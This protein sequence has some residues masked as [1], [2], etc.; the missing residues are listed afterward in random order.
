MSAPPGSIRWLFW[1]ELKL[2]WYSAGAGKPG[3][4][5]KPQRRPGIAGLATAALVWLA[6]H[7]VA[8]YVI[9]R[10]G[11]I[12]VADPRVLVAVTA[13]LFGCMT[14]MLSTALKSS[15]MVLFERGDLDLLLSSPLPSRSIFT[16]R[17][18]SVAAGTA[19]MY[20][21][22]LAPFAHAGALLGHARWLAVYPVILGSATVIACAAMLMTLGLVRVLGA[23][24]TRVV[25]QVIG[26][27]AGASLFLL[28]QLFHYFSS[29]M[30]AR[31]TAAFA[32]AF[33]ANGALGAA[34]PVWLP[35]RALLG[36]PLP[37]LGIALVALAAFA[38]TAG[39]THRFFVHGLQQAASTGRAARRPAGGV[40]YR[41]GRS[42]FATVL[43]KEWRLV[44]RDPH[45]ISQVAL[46]LIYLL[47]L[48]F[49][50]FR[51]SEVQLPMLA[52]GLTLLCSSL[53]AS[54]AW[55]TV[56]AEDAPDLLMMAPA[57]PW[58]VRIAKLAAAVLPSL[59]IVLPPLAW[60]GMRAPATA[61][62][63]GLSLTGAVCA[64]A[65]IVHWCAQPGLR[66]DYL[67]RGRSDYLTSIL[68]MVNSL[69]WG[70]VTWTLTATTAAPSKLETAASV[71]APIAVF[72]TLFVSWL[73][74]RSRP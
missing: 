26:A 52:A 39:R 67:A 69:A 56:S 10:T 19:V 54:L 73:L 29:S 5:G 37:A 41:F 36:E 27:L 40:R 70:G 18:A 16:V 2:L 32:Q 46:Q 33:A 49:I 35:G 1:H 23:R 12:D 14:F 6:L 22:F 60:L 44:V 4:P 8:Y 61:L 3:K 15:V 72:L 17:L 74:R 68:E 25:A 31:A 71:V 53:T 42:L 13:L 28:S 24:R 50:A 47:P 63:A 65:V 45:L 11:G 66:S 38:F 64:A 43:L 48:C 9:K 30:E 34:S 51:R 59:G 20:L 62:L 7:G 55:I 58:T 21:F 57:R